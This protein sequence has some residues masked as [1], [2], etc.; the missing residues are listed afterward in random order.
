M[1]PKLARKP[2][3]SGVLLVD[4]PAG[5]T[6]HDV[7][8][9]V[10]RIFGQREVGHTGT[11][12][13][14]AT[15]LLVLTLGRATR[16]ARF[17]EATEKVYTGT[18]RL[19]RATTTYDAEGDT[20]AEVGP[21]VVAAIDT[22]RIRAALASLTGSIQQTV[23]AFS[24]VKV[25]GERL[26]AKARRGEAVDAPVREV[27]IHALELLRFAPPD[28]DVEARVSKGT[29]IRSLA[30][31]IGDALGVPAHLAALRR[32][33]VGSHRVE[34]ARTLDALTGDPSELVA[35]ADALGELARIVLDAERA[36]DVTFGRPLPIEALR[37]LELGGRRAGDPLRLVDG[38]G[39]LLAI[40]LFE[41]DGDVLAT[42][43]RG[44]RA[45]RYACVLTGAGAPP[46]EV[47]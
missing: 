35:P 4:K 32:T 16:L 29:Y 24:A 41:H 46:S 9:R 18:V 8:G 20:T 31:Q 30:V 12:D 37:G 36:R 14:M 27:D 5:I 26:Y 40:G 38:R 33:R 39:E 42:A 45:V 34:D 7:V 21:E 2:A 11:L 13:P 43:P 10:R 1:T 22:P 15:G 17:I 6:S 44:S 23:P 28:V 25:D 47:A 19:G 3:A